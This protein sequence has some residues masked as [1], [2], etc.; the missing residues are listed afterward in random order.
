MIYILS[1][2][3]DFI[4]LNLCVVLMMHTQVPLEEHAT[5]WNTTL[6]NQLIVTN[7]AW[8]ITVYLANYYTEPTPVKF[9][10]ELPKMIMSVLLL[11]GT[12]SL[13]VQF[14]TPTYF[15]R[16][17]AFFTFGLFFLLLVANR[18]LYYFIIRQRTKNFTYALAG[19]PSVE[20]I[21]QFDKA[22]K[23]FYGQKTKC[24]GIFSKEQPN[25]T[26]H[27][28]GYD[29]ITEF[30]NLGHCRLNKLIYFENAIP[31]KILKEVIRT[32]RLKGIDLLVI[33]K[34]MSFFSPGL[35]I[36]AI[37]T[38][39]VYGKR[40]APLDRARNKILKRL[41]DLG[42]AFFILVFILSWLVPIIALLVRRSSP[43]PIFFVQERT[44]LKNKSFKCLKF[45]S[46]TVNTDS[47]TKQATKGDSRITPIG[48]FLRKSN[49]D[50]IPQFFNVLKGDMSI[51]GPRPHMLKHTEY[52]SELIADFMLRHEV[53]P[54]ITGWA[55]VNGWRGPTDELYK[56]ENRVKYDI[57]YVDNWR[58]WWD[59]RIIFLTAFNMVKGEENA[60]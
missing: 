30:I 29:S 22:F 7:I 37:D 60:F 25:T 24:I 10:D 43:G 31:E 42:F 55:Q 26:N 11:T 49:L 15:G 1:V 14:V 46:M 8:L 57:E 2:V 53:K 20:E 12:V 34:Y 13:M 39:P 35:A 28:G 51:V 6:I 58:F 41:V 54:G 52:Y 47:D 19:Q 38:Y 36:G 16:S 56:M 21:N 59:F 23:N 18:F 48:A 9:R 27:L 33:P 40:R 4:L 17:F 3:I 5:N 50:E 32:C 44:G 45:R